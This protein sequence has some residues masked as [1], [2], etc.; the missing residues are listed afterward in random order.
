[1]K[2]LIGSAALLLLLGGCGSASKEWTPHR[3]RK[4]YFFPVRQYAPDPVYSRVRAVYP[5]EPRQS[6]SAPEYSAPIIEPV[7]SL[8]VRNGVV[9]MAARQLAA[10]SGYATYCSSLVA[11]KSL[12]LVTS[13]SIDEL[14]RRVADTAGVVV[15][16]DHERRALRILSDRPLPEEVDH[17]AP[18]EVPSAWAPVSGIRGFA[19]VDVQG[20]SPRSSGGKSQ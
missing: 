13:G 1:M 18:L 19:P 5:P 14:A 16:V 6:A 3:A 12:T 4:Y 17:A 9:E 7:F 20:R 11:Q 15:W 2:R 10:Q 8:S